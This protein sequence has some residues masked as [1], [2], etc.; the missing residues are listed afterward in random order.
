MPSAV[1]C[2]GC[3]KTI[4]KETSSPVYANGNIVGHVH[5]LSS[6]TTTRI[7]HPCIRLA[8]WHLQG[9]ANA[10]SSIV[11]EG[12]SYDIR[13]TPRPEVKRPSGSGASAVPYAHRSNHASSFPFI[14][15]SRHH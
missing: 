7:A 5:K 2:E 9:G 1:A 13:N 11:V 10:F 14:P 4:Y 12:K 3:G 6:E 8:F 15:P